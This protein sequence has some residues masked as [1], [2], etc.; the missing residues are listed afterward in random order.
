MDLFGPFAVLVLS[1][2][3]DEREVFVP[4]A[5]DLFIGLRLAFEPEVRETAVDQPLDLVRLERPLHFEFNRVDFRRVQ[6]PF[7]IP[8]ALRRRE[9][10][11]VRQVEAHRALLARIQ[12]DAGVDLAVRQVDVARAGLVFAAARDV[13]GQPHLTVLR[14]VFDVHREIF[15]AGE[16]ELLPFRRVDPQSGIPFRRVALEQNAVGGLLDF[17]PV[18]GFQLILRKFQPARQQTAGAEDQRRRNPCSA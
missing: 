5:G 17:G 6:R 11:R 4:H 8:A 18:P 15:G 16:V 9:K 3:I 14:E 2:D 10:R 7:D 1:V 13:H 12:A